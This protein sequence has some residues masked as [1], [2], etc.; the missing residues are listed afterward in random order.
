MASIR[1]T[2]C[3]IEG[4]SEPDKALLFIPL[5]SPAPKGDSARLFLSAL[6]GPGLSEQDPIALV[7]ESEKRIKD[8][9]QP[10]K[11]TE[12]CDDTDIHYGKAGR[13]LLPK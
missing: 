1:R 10:E 8:V 4:L 11:L 5:S 2:L 7:V 12:R 13:R 6:S 9:T 3:K